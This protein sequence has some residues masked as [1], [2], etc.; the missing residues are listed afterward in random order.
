VLIVIVNLILFIILFKF[1]LTLK[2]QLKKSIMFDVSYLYFYKLTVIPVLLFI[3]NFVI[4]YFFY[5]ELWI[6]SFIPL[7]IPIYRYLYLLFTI[8]ITKSEYNSLE[9]TIEPVILNEFTNRNLILNPNNISIRLKDKINKKQ[10]LEI[11]I[12]I[13]ENYLFLDNIKMSIKKELELKLN[14][15]NRYLLTV[16]IKLPYKKKDKTYTPCLI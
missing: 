11:V 12:N 4:L 13:E 10:E 6:Y 5:N 7:L 16:I 3:I 8:L 9:E 2:K 14:T 1:F 15:N